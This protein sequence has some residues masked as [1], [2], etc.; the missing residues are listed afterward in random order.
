MQLHVDMDSPS[1]SHA[2]TEIALLARQ[3]VV[4]ADDALMRLYMLNWRVTLSVFLSEI[5]SREQ[6]FRTLWYTFGAG[7]IPMSQ[8][9]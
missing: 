8:K 9:V 2:L 4:V 3:E 7:L 1:P 5:I 6:L